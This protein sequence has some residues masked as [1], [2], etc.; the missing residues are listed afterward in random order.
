MA[1]GVRGD[2]AVPGFFTGSQALPVRQL[3]SGL[4]CPAS[5]LACW[6]SSA[7]KITNP[8]SAIGANVGTNNMNTKKTAGIS[9]AESINT[10]LIAKLIK[11]IA[12]RIDQA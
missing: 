6:A 2:L 5:S 3:I 7:H 8:T 1:R 10:I 11:V 9:A 4:C 12:S